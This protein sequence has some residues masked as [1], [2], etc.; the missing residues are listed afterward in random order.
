MPRNV[1]LF[2]LNRH[3]G[4][5]SNELCRDVYSL[6]ILPGERSLVILPDERIISYYIQRQ[7]ERKTCKP[8]IDAA[9]RSNREGPGEANHP[10]FFYFGKPSCAAGFD[11]GENDGC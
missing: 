7:R 11:T 9:A 6:V 1:A 3:R 10:V 4:G 8:H 5:S 2:W